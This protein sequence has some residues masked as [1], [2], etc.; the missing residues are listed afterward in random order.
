MG[1]YSKEIVRNPRWYNF[2]I[3]P[4]STIHVKAR[5]KSF[6]LEYQPLKSF[7]VAFRGLGCRFLFSTRFFSPS[8]RVQ[9]SAH[10]LFVILYRAVHIVNGWKIPPDNSGHP[11]YLFWVPLFLRWFVWGFMILPIIF[12]LLVHY[13]HGHYDFWA[14]VHGS[15]RSWESRNS[16]VPINCTLCQSTFMA[17]LLATYTKNATHN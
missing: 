1:F 14:D 15:F 12:F 11:N 5:L 2:K 16:F 13:M 3:N 4:P 9:H 6:L 7:K 8:N 17:L 10:P